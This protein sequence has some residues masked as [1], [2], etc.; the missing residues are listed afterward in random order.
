MY[1]LTKDYM[2]YF[3][4]ENETY[5]VKEHKTHMDEYGGTH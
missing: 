3:K 4:P 5:P 1:M 2:R